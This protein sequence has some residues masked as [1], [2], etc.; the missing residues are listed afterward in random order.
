MTDRTQKF[1]EALAVIQNRLG[2]LDSLINDMK[3]VVAENPESLSTE[4]LVSGRVIGPFPVPT[5]I[6]LNPHPGTC[7]AVWDKLGTDMSFVTAT[8]RLEEGLRSCA[9]FTNAVIRH[10]LEGMG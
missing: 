10:A 1:D 3:Q 9:D 5:P 4:R 7:H 8:V 2:E 6:P